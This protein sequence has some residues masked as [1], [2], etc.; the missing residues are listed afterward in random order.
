MKAREIFKPA[1]IARSPK[2]IKLLRIMLG[3]SH[4]Q[5]SDRFRC[6]ISSVKKWEQPAIKNGKENLE[7]REPSGSE[8]L[9]LHWA[10]VEAQERGCNTGNLIRWA[11]MYGASHNND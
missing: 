4:A 7:H 2:E 3:E 9:L 10:A 11:S 1:V 5:W 6:S 8:Y